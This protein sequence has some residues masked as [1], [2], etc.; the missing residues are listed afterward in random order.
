MNQEPNQIQKYINEDVKRLSP[1]EL[2]KAYK[3]VRGLVSGNPVYGKVE[4]DKSHLII[5]TLRSHLGGGQSSEL[6]MVFNTKNGE[7]QIV[8]EKAF[9]RYFGSDKMED[10]REF[11]EKA[12]DRSWT[13]EIKDLVGEDQ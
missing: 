2:T 11:Y 8:V 1:E 6:Y 4:T 9:L 7:T 10:A 5:N 12:T 3:F 13:L